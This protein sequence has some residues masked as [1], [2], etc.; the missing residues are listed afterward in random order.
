MHRP[1]KRREDNLPV[2]EGVMNSHDRFYGAF[3]ASFAKAEHTTSIF[4][5]SAR[6]L[7]W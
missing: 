6:K 1:K 7:L 4:D 2:E 3:V 5:Q